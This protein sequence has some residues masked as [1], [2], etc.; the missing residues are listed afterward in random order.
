MGPRGRC[1]SSRHYVGV[2]ALAFWR[3]HGSVERVRVSCFVLSSR[4]TNSVERLA[5]AVRREMAKRQASSHHLNSKLGCRNTVIFC[6]T[7]FCGFLRAVSESGGLRQRAAGPH[8]G[9]RT[10]GPT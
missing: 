4:R 1:A 10:E 8:G 9:T 3:R 7:G 2:E 5:S 6:G